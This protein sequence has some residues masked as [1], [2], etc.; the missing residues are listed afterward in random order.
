MYMYIYMYI[1]IYTHID[2]YMI[3]IFHAEQICMAALSF[4]SPTCQAAQGPASSEE[5]DKHGQPM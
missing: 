2:V 5:I 1:Y 4:I 3:Q